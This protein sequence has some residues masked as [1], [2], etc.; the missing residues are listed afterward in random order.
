MASFKYTFNKYFIA[1]LITFIVFFTLSGQALCAKDYGKFSAKLPPGTPILR[2]ATGLMPIKYLIDRVGGEYVDTLA[3]LPAGSDPHTYEP[4][5]S[6]L[7]VLN[8]ADMY[9]NI[10]SP[11][12]TNWLPR[13]A[14]VNNRMKLVDLTELLFFPQVL[15]LPKAEEAALAK[16]P[17]HSKSKDNNTRNESNEGNSTISESNTEHSSHSHSGHDPHIWLSPKL[18]SK[19]A[20]YICVELSGLMPENKLYFE[21]NL[22]KLQAQ[23]A[24]LDES[25]KKRADSLPE[26]KKLFLVFH[27]S[28]GYFADDYGLTQIAVEDDGKEPTPATLAKIL[29]KAKNANISTILVQKEFNPELAQTVAAHFP[30]GRVVVLDPLGYN[31]LTS[32]RSAANAILGPEKEPEGQGAS[33]LNDPNTYIPENN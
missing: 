16:D 31:P 22:R 3:L 4:K 12:E 18:L 28:W 13:F 11:F 25:I 15:E 1:L 17:H 20:E 8:D 7:A 19:M 33:D 2:V 30:N 29:D 27:P 23:L 24:E 32:I 14:A 5:I 26:N 10:D 9:L 6:Q 21:N